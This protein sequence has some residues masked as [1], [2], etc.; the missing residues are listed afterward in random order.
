MPTRHAISFF[1][2]LIAVFYAAV[3]Q[4]NGPAYFPAYALFSLLL[5]S[6]I[7]NRASVRDLEITTQRRVH[8]FAGSVVLI[9]FKITNKKTRLKFG[10]H[11]TTNLGGKATLGRLE[12]SL[13]GEVSIPDLKRGIYTI[14]WLGVTSIFPMGV[15]ESKSR[16]PVQCECVVYPEPLGDREVP[17]GSGS[18]TPGNLGKRV[19]GDDFAGV[20][21]Y[22]VGESQRHIDWKAVA[23]GQPLM[24]KQFETIS[25]QE[26]MLSTETLHD[27]E[28]EARLCQLARWVVLSERAGIRYGLQIGGVRI[29][30]G[31]GNTHYHHCLRTLATHGLGKGRVP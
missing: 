11:V 30:P 9:P 3:S 31:L 21:S 26:I 6:W 4:G 1:L 18:G 16:H 22:V 14:D 5:V 29:Q 10:L 20:K 15:F 23:R 24:V 28:I 7:H 8:G 17:G 27:I 12:T 13:D 19:P 2:V 25:H